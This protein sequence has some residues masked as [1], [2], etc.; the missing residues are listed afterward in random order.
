M[1]VVLCRSKR[2]PDRWSP[3]AVLLEGLEAFDPTVIAYGGLFW[4]WVCLSGRG[5]NANDE[6]FL[7]SAGHPRGPWRGHPSNPV[8]SDAGRA[9]P[10]GRPFVEDGRL[11]R[12]SQD[13]RERY[14]REVV[15]NEIDT[16]TPTAYREDPIGRIGLGWSRGI[17][18]SHT[19]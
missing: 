13:C 14:G 18:A 17:I 5:Q 15:I 7:Y 6:L 2:F 10:A 1:I 3:E 8:V 11:M 4:M 19:L 16:L 12:P 9:R